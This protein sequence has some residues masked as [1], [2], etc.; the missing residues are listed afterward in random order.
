ML[1]VL[2]GLGLCKC[3]WPWILTHW[4]WGHAN[5][6]NRL[7]RLLQRFQILVHQCF[8]HCCLTNN[9]QHFRFTESHCCLS[10]QFHIHLN[11]ML[12]A[13]IWL[14]HTAN[15]TAA[16]QSLLTLQHPSSRRLKTLSACLQEQRSPH[17]SV[18]EWLK[19]VTAAGPVVP[20]PSLAESHIA[21]ARQS[22]IPAS[23]TTRRSHHSSRS[24]LAVEMM[25]RMADQNRA[26]AMHRDELAHAEKQTLIQDAANRKNFGSSG[27]S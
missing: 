19:Q 10:N 18:H 13:L 6:F 7:L 11:F 9:C 25:V 20:P 26:D 14:R 21:S 23:R 17:D 3:L 12:L 22:T 5:H 15:E 16:A 8:T 1:Q 24:S 2:W 27:S 4:L